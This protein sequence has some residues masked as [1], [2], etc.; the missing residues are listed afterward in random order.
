[1]WYAQFIGSYF[2]LLDITHYLT[3]L[4]YFLK[5]HC[6]L[7]CTMH[8]SVSPLTFSFSKVEAYMFF[9]LQF[10]VLATHLHAL[11]ALTVAMHIL[12]ETTD[13]VMY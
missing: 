13:S 12:I 5:I 4:F 11:W 7:L 3:L 6:A 9:V 10:L 1:M 8:F 2:R